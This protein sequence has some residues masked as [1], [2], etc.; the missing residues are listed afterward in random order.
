MSPATCGGGGTANVCGS[1]GNLVWKKANLTYFTSYPDP[2]SEE[3]IK[4]NGCMWAGQFA[5]VDGK[6]SESWV[7]ANNI[8]AI[9]EK[10]AEQVQAEDPAPAAGQQADR[11][12]GLRHVL[13]LAT[14]AAAAPRTPSRTV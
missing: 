2:G 10:D 8:A 1:G 13:G 14:A 4:Y 6:Q 9:H 12:Q 3:C 7:K 5:F 11:R